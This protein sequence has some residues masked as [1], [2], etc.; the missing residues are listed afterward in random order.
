MDATR[1]PGSRAEDSFDAFSPKVSG[2][3]RLAGVEGGTEPT[4]NVYGAYSQ[5]FLPPRAPSSLTPANVAV[6]LVPED[7][8]N[9][10][11]GVKAAV[12][13]GTVALEASYFQMT[14]DG[15][16]LSQRQGPLFIPTNAGQRKYKGFETG[17]GWAASAAVTT[18]VNAGF[19]HHRYGDF[20]I[21]S[22][23]G[24]T[25]L[26]GNRLEMSPDYIIS[27]GAV[28]RP[29]RPVTVTFDVKHVGGVMVD[30][31]NTFELDKYTL[32]DASVSWQ[33]RA[34]RI[35]LSAHNLFDEEYYWNGGSD[36]ESADPA[37][38]RQ[39]LV[40]TALRFR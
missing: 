23:D 24:D 34:L 33:V 27:W 7:I 9:Y 40:T 37:R 35:T 18:Y 8:E 12:L 6:E 22:D 32:V 28:A 13:N 4:V 10:E 20:T 16:V 17:A 30:E 21:E 29:A 36:A 11:G 2:T 1:T 14:E 25:V 3:F 19:Y 38:P 5:A 31:T 15:V 39:V 26:D